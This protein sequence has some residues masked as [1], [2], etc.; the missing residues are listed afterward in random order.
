M[1]NTSIPMNPLLLKKSTTSP[2]DEETFTCEKC[3]NSLLTTM[4]KTKLVCTLMIKTEDGKIATFTC[5]NNA[6]QSFLITISNQTPSSEI[7]TNELKTMFLCAGS[8]QMIVDK[9]T[10]I[11]DQF[12]L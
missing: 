7:N 6:M 10:R 8:K 5:F 9:A 12:L 2:Q 11:I 3:H 4:H 1:K